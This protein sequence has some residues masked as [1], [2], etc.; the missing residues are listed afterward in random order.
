MSLLPREL[1][2]GAL[3]PVFLITGAEPLLVERAALAV[4]ERALEQA[5]P[6][7]FNAS[8]HR[9]S[10]AD[11]ED[12]IAAART[13][14]MMAALRVVAVRELE[15]GSDTFFA[16]LDAYLAAPSP[17]TV[18]VLSG[19][20][21]PAV[22][23]GGRNWSALVGAK[24]KQQ[25][26]AWKF[27]ERDADPVA[28]VIAQAE[29]LGHPLAADAARLM[30]ALVGTDLSTLSREVDKATLYVAPGAP[31][32]AAAVSAACSAIAETEVWDL[33]AA[34]ARRDGEGALTALRRLLD[35][36]VAAHQVLG[37]LGWQ[38]RVILKVAEA[39]RRGLPEA[40]IQQAAGRLSRDAYRKLRGA[41]GPRTPGAA[42]ALETLA[43]AN[44]MLHSSRADEGRVLEALL[45]Q[46]TDPPSAARPA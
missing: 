14:P 1:V 2:D 4:E 43:R 27:G 18:L 16:A 46:L 23:K 28:F 29:A 37:L 26:L 45:L 22:R 35:Q 3:H 32:D 33:T 31:V 20:G 30:V 38:L 39:V 44:R 40:E 15:A 21:F 41:V 17:T 24:A 5:A 10:D 13:P 34:V 6:V 8:R 42:E 36:E 25:G 12:A 19:R 9:A 11:A 7:S